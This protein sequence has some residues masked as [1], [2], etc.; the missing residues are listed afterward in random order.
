MAKV[1]EKP[2]TLDGYVKAF[3]D[4][5]PLVS[6]SYGVNQIFCDVCRVMSLSLRGVFAREK[7]KAEIEDAYQ[8]F[9]SKYGRE[10]MDKIADLFAIVVKAL[11]TT[12]TDFLGQVYERLNA[13]VKNFGQYLTPID[14][15]RLLAMIVVDG[16]PESGVIKRMY[17]PAC[18]AGVL[19]LESSKRFL[20][21]GGRQA[22]VLIYADDLDDTACCIAY[23]QLTLL[24]YAAVVRRVDSLS[25]KVFEGPWYTAG[26]FLHGFPTRLLKERFAK[27]CREEE[28]NVDSDSKTD[29]AAD[30]TS[31][32]NEVLNVRTAELVQGEL[33]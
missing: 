8:R 10:G 4:G 3:V 30:E 32:P 12:S 5:L 22:D 11:E 13:T 26:Y 31:K 2:S 9:V 28:K 7:E 17:D 20:E 33:F 25:Q 24:G 27:P 23:V 18:G 15:S 21:V 19:L 14:V 29:K 6:Q 1:K 16:K